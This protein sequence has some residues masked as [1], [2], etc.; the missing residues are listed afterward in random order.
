[1]LGRAGEALTKTL[2]LNAFINLMRQDIAYY[3]D[4]RHGTGKLCTRFATDAPNVR[5]VSYC[6]LLRI[7]FTLP[8]RYNLSFS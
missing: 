7:A 2:R 5:Y 6:V 8:K 1:M 4:E 3:D